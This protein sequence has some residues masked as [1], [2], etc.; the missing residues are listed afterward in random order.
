M[1]LG[2]WG[3]VGLHNPIFEGGGGGILSYIFML[4]F[5]RAHALLFCTQLTFFVLVT[6]RVP[7]YGFKGKTS[8]MKS[9]QQGSQ[10]KL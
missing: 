2:W 9:R 6:W 10:Q 8:N 4:F 1:S 3:Y 5:P 7:A